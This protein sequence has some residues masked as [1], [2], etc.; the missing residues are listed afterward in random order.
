MLRYTFSKTKNEKSG[1]VIASTRPRLISSLLAAANLPETL[2]SLEALASTL[3]SKKSEWTAKEEQQAKT[4]LFRCRQLVADSGNNNNNNSNNN[5]NNN[6]AS[7]SASDIR[8]ICLLADQLGSQMVQKNRTS[9]APD[10]FVD[11]LDFYAALGRP[12]ITQSAF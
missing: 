8:K 6:N 10:I 12:D 9:F 2:D 1:L 3:G 7:R 4:V 5:N 11:Y